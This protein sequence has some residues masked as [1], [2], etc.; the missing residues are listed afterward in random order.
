MC[1]INIFFFF[2]GVLLVWGALRLYRA[3]LKVAQRTRNLS[4]T[5]MDDF[6]EIF[7]IEVLGHSVCD[8]K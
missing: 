7:Q 6:L 5:V 8:P 1:K 3:A 4:K 2:K